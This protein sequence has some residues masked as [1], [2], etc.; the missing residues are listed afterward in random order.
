[1]RYATASAFRTALEQRLLTAARQTNVP[2]VRL[3]KLVVFERLLARLIVVSQGRWILKGALALDFRLS[4]GFRTTQDMDLV[5]SD[6]EGSATADF[7][8]AQVV[9]LQDH[10]SFVVQR[11]ARLDA[12][13]EGAAVRYHAHAELAGRTFEDVIVDVGFGDPLVTAPDLV[14]GPGLLG[15]AGIDPIEVP[16]LPVEQQIAEKVHAYTRQYI[17]GRHSSRVKDLVDLVLIRSHVALQARSLRFALLT[18]FEHRGS[19]RLP[20]KLPLPPPEWGP[21]Y[22]K[23]ASLVGLSPELWDGHR[24][25][26]AFLDPVLDGSV[27]DGAYWYPDAGIWRVTQ[28]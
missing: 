24:L 25:A 23:M 19:H 17:G 27:S 11:T 10:F 20:A 7:I 13:T 8:A 6:D 9:D 2:V 18:V 12:A 22:R 3:R 5:R 4:S 28:E 15:F 1:M 26:A 21:P 16:V 14:T